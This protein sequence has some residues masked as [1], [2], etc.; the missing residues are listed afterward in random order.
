MLALHG[1]AQDVGVLR[2]PALEALLLGVALAVNLEEGEQFFEEAVAGELEGG[3]GALEALEEVGPDE[4]DHLSLAVFLERV[5]VLV[6]PPVPMQGVVHGE[7]EE[8]VLLRK[9]FLKQV[10]HPP[11]GFSDRVRR[12]L[13]VSPVGKG[14][15]LAI[16]PNLA[17]AGVRAAPLDD[18]V[19]EECVGVEDP[20]GFGHVLRGFR[21]VVPHPAAKRRF[22]LVEVRPQVVHADRARKVGLVATREELGHVAEVAQAVVDGG[23]R[24]HVHGLGAFRVGEQIVQAV[25]AGRLL[26]VIAASPARVPEVV[27]FVDDHDVGQLGNALETLRE[28][29]FSSEV[30]VAE[31]G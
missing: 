6:S 26:A 25:V 2:L 4:A 27:C 21:L 14:G 7:R 1:G 3:D 8:R 22:H 11:V 10:E 24:Q 17:L 18:D 5:D 12:H 31:D 23:G 28:V 29:A 16:L 19:A 15:C 13:R 30:S 20:L 9:G